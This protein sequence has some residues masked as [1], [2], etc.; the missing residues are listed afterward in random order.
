VTEQAPVAVQRQ[1][2]VHH[3]L[4]R[5]GFGEVYRA[6]MISPGGLKS[7]VAIKVLRLD[8]NPGGEAVR[9]LRDEA[10]LLAMLKHPAILKAHD[11]AF[12]N[13]QVALVTEFVEGEDLT[14]CVVGPESIGQRALLEV[15]GNVAEALHVAYTTASPDTG[16]PLKLVHRDVK[17]S[18]IRLSPHGEVKLLDFGIAWSED[19]DREAKTGTNATIGSLAYMAPE[20]FAKGP[21]LAASDIYALGCT[22]YEGI[23]ADRLFA[24]A[25]PVEMYQ[26]AADRNVHEQFVNERLEQVKDDRL[27][28]LL[29]LMLAHKP[30]D[31]PNAADVAQRCEQLV[32]ALSGPRLRAWCRQRKWPTPEAVPGML[33]G[34][35]ITEG[36]LPTSDLPM[37]GRPMPFPTGGDPTS[38]ETTFELPQGGQTAM[39]ATGRD[40]A[41]PTIALTT[42]RMFAEPPPPAPAR[43]LLLPG[44]AA[45]GAGC[46]LLLALGWAVTMGPLW[47]HPEPPS[48]PIVAPTMPVPPPVETS[49]PPPVS[50]PAPAVEASAVPPPVEV[51][52]VATPAIA[53]PTSKPS[54]SRNPRASKPPPV[55]AKATP[56]V[57]PV[58]APVEPPP[59]PPKPPGTVRVVGEVQNVELKSGGHTL[60]PGNDVPPGSY[61]VWADFGTGS[62]AQT[63]IEV[64]SG[65]TVTI[66]CNGLKFSCTVD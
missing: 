13:K 36:T 25:V 62:Y 61:E 46:T 64:L 59:P 7:D 32:E 57:V 40:P 14:H 10:K 51:P 28:I 56:P 38:S 22:L 24:D 58:T 66:R 39:M 2:N 42:A 49:P 47:A 5:G 60:S 52:P 8:V 35:V 23:T 12:L 29:Q 45:V 16:N 43:N 19:V 1:F 63:R 55:E 37:F 9:R 15:I 18:N 48:L 44:L 53:T 11:L 20:R 65:G 26:R 31:R 27:R 30:A 34:R 54:S 41:P 17:P 50:P 33:D 3:C 6:T 21:A 4:G